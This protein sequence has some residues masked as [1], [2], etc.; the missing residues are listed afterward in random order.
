MPTNK[1]PKLSVSSRP[2][3]VAYRMKRVNELLKAASEFLIAVSPTALGGNVHQDLTNILNR[4]SALTKLAAKAAPKKKVH[5]KVAKAAKAKKSAK[6]VQVP[7]FTGWASI[8]ESA[9][10]LDASL[11]KIGET[12]NVPEEPTVTV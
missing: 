5:K 3:D 7:E 10:A 2:C 4:S 12:V 6:A 1:S 11:I 8:A 9:K